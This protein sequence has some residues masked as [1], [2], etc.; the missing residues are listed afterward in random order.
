MLNK[1]LV[2]PTDRKKTLYAIGLFLGLFPRDSF[3]QFKYLFDENQENDIEKF[4]SGILQNLKHFGAMMLTDENVVQWN[5]RFQVDSYLQMQQK[6]KENK[7]VLAQERAS[8]KKILRKYIVPDQIIREYDTSCSRGGLI[9]KVK[10]VDIDS[11]L[12][13]TNII[14][15]TGWD[16][17][18]TEGYV[19]VWHFN[20]CGDNCIIFEAELE[21]GQ[22]TQSLLYLGNDGN[23]V[24]ERDS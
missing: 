17:V 22:G 15:N 11:L 24:I 6:K 12:I 9:L 10:H 1:L 13:T 7:A 21:S 4:L 20:G 19:A 8:A 14:K 2:N 18:F 23:I 5:E 3:E 16:Y